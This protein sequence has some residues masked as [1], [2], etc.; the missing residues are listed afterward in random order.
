MPRSA[1][2]NAP[3]SPPE[4]PR[5]QE[6]RRQLGEVFPLYCALLESGPF[7][8]EWRYYGPKYGWSL[9]LFEKKRN[10][11]FIGPKEG[12]FTVAFIFGDRVRESALAGAAEEEDKALLRSARHY[13]E[14]WG[15]TLTV[16]GAADLERARSLLAIK[17]EK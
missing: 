12:A 1:P 5:E 8:P 11:C 17:R 6:I 16:T 7:R 3:T 10:L 4:P 2:S 15:V 14:G 13:P 9:K